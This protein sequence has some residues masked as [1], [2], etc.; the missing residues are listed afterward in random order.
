[1]EREGS[2]RF[3]ACVMKG[4]GCYKISSMLQT[5]AEY[6]ARTSLERPLLSGVAYAERVKNSESSEFERQNG[7]TIK[8]ME[9]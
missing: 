3:G 6:A 7:F 9:D 1:M 2:K 4:Q 5:F 8:T